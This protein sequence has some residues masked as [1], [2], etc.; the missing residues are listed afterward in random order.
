MSQRFESLQPPRRFYTEVDMAP[1]DRGFGVRLDG[2]ALRT[3]MAHPL[4]LPSEA[5]ARLVAAEWADQ[6]ERIVMAAMPATRLAHTAIDAVPLARPETAAGVAGFA[7]A[8]LVCYFAPGPA[9]L[10]ARQ[11]EV[12]GPLL[13]WARSDLG[14]AFERGEG[15]VHRDQ[16]AATL[17]KVEALAA[18]RA[19]FPLAGLAF[20]AQLFGSAI[21]ALALERGRLDGNQAFAASRIDETFQSGQW[22]EDAEA[23]AQARALQAEALML[24]HWFAAL[25]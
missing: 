6:G 20:A 24:G 13:A 5:L 11:E 4:V 1:A 3:P 23:A 14:L 9:S 8:D 21:L 15:V 18:R 17:A 22:G 12:W 19:D 16:P 7:A 10:R 2:R 25:R